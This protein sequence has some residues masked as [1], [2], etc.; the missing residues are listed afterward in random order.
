MTP[1]SLAQLAADGNIETVCDA[2]MR[3]FEEATGPLHPLAGYR[4]VLTALAG[5]G[6]AAQAEELA[7]TA[8]ELLSARHEP[9]AILPVAGGLL[10]AVEDSE[11]VRGQ[12]VKLYRMAYSDREGIGPLL[13]ESGLGG[14]RP[15]RRALRTLE[16]CLALKEGDY[17]A[18]RDDDGAARVESID[19]SSWQLVVTGREGR[20]T[21]DAVR[22]ADQY[23]P[24]PFTHFAV[25]RQFGPDRLV[26]HLW[27]KPADVLTDLCRSREGR[28]D[29]DQLERLL[30]PEL[31]SDE[32]W[33][34]W[35]TRA[36]TALRKRPSFRITG[37]SPYEIVYDET[38]VPL[39]GEM[40]EAFKRRHDPLGKLAVID[41][42]VRDCKMQNEEPSREAIQTCLDRLT[43]RAEELSRDG[44]AGAILYWL[45]ACSAAGLVGVDPPSGAV[46][47][48]R[49]STDLRSVF[50]Q[51]GDPALTGLAC[52]ML[53]DA[54][55]DDWSDQLLA[56]LPMLPASVCEQA[57]ER[58]VAAGR[59]AQD[60]EPVI[61]QILASP[62]EHFE[63]LLWLWD[64]PSQ[65][66]HL[67]C[68]PP[69][70]VLSRILRTLDECRH[71]E[72]I[73]RD[74]VK[75]ITGRARAVLSARKYERF[76]RCVAGL[77][78][79]M[80][81]ALRTQ[82]RRLDNL[83]RAV[84]SD[85][86]NHLDRACPPIRQEKRID[87]WTLEDVLFVTEDGLARKQ[88][89]IEHHVNVKMKENAEAIGRAA[90]HGDLS[91]N[92]EYKFALEERDLLRARLAQ[93]NAEVAAARVIAPADVP[94][95]HAGIGTKVVF[96]RESDGAPYEMTF[97]GPW[98]ADP[99]KHWFNYQAPL[100]KKVLGRH[101]GD[102]VEFD[103]AGVEGKYEIVALANGLTSTG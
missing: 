36:R 31:L 17:L 47:V 14:G 71:N 75:A 100:A 48:L 45:V 50:A 29:S 12:V 26:E 22:L 98:E 90:E 6:H 59:A 54:R 65:T 92:S 32:E 27:S 9:A 60:F 37:R 15:V 24:A 46:D 70:T 49:S 3:V 42:Y 52:T 8:L 16:V 87:P 82:L 74:Q 58:L 96:K 30:V 64:G 86:V 38:P 34:K 44:A 2:W 18:A 94:T 39:D 56:L 57:T 33:K 53:P 10:S 99:T 40:L 55:P 89:D 91:E 67:P 63:A 25:M 84:R 97:V 51:L 35:W 23:Y 4:D 72:S 66:D 78:S 68:P 93:M 20:E 21:L 81:S 85:L 28:L 77:E 43:Q 73:M 76:D 41:K 62:V 101:V 11:E 103:H 61:D 95:D 88:D 19:A 1:K 83:G 102:I 5:S 69:I 7:W 79:G 80:G 13:E